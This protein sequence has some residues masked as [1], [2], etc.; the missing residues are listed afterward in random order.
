MKAKPIGIKRAGSYSG[1]QI[2]EH[3]VS[4]CFHEGATRMSLV[5]SRSLSFHDRTQKQAL[6]TLVLNRKEMYKYMGTK[7]C[8]QFSTIK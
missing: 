7:I 2:P 6:N 4:Q 8:W 3:V 5:F 1:P